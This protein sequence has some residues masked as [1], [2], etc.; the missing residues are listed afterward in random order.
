MTKPATGKIGLGF[1]DIFFFFCALSLGSLMTLLAAVSIERLFDQPTLDA[2]R[3]SD[4][5]MATWP[6]TTGHLDQVEIFNHKHRLGY[7]VYWS[8]HYLNYHYSVDGKPYTGHQL[9]GTYDSWRALENRLAVFHIDRT[10]AKKAASESG[11]EVYNFDQPIDVYYD[12][13]HFENSVPDNHPVQWDWLSYVGVKI[14]LILL[15]LALGPPL[16]G[17]CTYAALLKFGFFKD[18]KMKDKIQNA[19]IFSGL[20]PLGLFTVCAGVGCFLQGQS[21]GSEVVFMH[22]VGIFISLFGA[23]II[24]MSFAW[25]QN[26][27]R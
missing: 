17:A 27:V 18:L 13:Q 21:S 6:V 20:F 14:M 26:R 1:A 19:L 12:P 2:A 4:L 5:A 9:V 25:L 7:G 24:L 10:H 23:V 15:G 22:V 11:A 8:Y 3:R 16:L